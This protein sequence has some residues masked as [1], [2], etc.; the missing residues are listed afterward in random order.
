MA[1]GGP[2]TYTLDHFRVA[3]SVMFVFWFFGGLQVWRYRRKSKVFLER[4]PGS[5]ERLRG[6]ETLLPG[7]SRD[8]D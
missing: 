1:P 2:A 3:M 4:V 8:I 5:I 7:I 6:G